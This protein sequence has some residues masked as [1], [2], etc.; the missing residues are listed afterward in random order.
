MSHFE[1]LFLAYM[2]SVCQKNPDPSHDLLHVQR[3]VA[4]AK[5]LAQQENASLNIVTPAAYLHDCFF[6]LKTDARRSQASTLSANQALHLLTEWGY[7]SEYHQGIHHAI[8]AHSFSAN[9]TPKTLEAKIVQD[10]DRLDALGAIG[11]LRCFSFGGLAQR[12]IYCGNDPFCD[13]RE[14]NDLSNSLDHFFTKLLKLPEKLHTQAAKEE[15]QKRLET[16]KS[17]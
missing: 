10:A 6:I 13:S 3:V 14:P 4:L 7:P 17:F 11:I 8:Q 5:T 9:I 16:M 1:N 12:P 2:E 15:G